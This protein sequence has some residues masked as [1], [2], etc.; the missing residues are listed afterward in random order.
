MHRGQALWQ[1]KEESMAAVLVLIAAG[2]LLIA[3]LLSPR[4][5][6]KSE[7]Q[8]MVTDC[9]VDPLR[10]YGRHRPARRMTDTRGR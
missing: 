3:V 5:S 10:R 2:L 8:G 9:Q 1:T 7:R 4:D 6:T